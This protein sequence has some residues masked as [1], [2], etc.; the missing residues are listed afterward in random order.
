MKTYPNEQRY[1][2][3]LRKMSPEEKLMK[4][5]DLS[6]LANEAFKAGLRSRNPDMP[7]NELERLYQEKLASCHNQNY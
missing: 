4:A 1:H 7:E 2:D 5:F 6:D 3:I